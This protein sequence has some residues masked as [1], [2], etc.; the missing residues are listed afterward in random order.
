[1]SVLGF[2]A[3]NALMFKGSFVYFWPALFG[4][5]VTLVIG[6]VTEYYTSAEKKT[7]K[8]I[9]DS[10]KTGSATTIIIGIAK[11]MESTLIPVIAIILA[12]LGSFYIGD[13]YGVAIAATAMLSMT[14]IIVAVDAYGP[15]TDNAGG[16]AEMSKLPSKGQGNNR[17]A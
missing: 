2:L 14:A 9:A 15:I 1:M 13:F 12:A 6:W 11:G 10:A 7:V 5:L 3:V 8:Q 4:V 17:R 16:I